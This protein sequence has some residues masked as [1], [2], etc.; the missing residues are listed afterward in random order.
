MNFSSRCLSICH[1]WLCCSV[2]VVAVVADPILLHPFPTIDPPPTKMK[3]FVKFLTV[4]LLLLLLQFLFLLFLFQRLQF[5][6]ELFFPRE[7]F[8]RTNEFPRSLAPRD[9]EQTRNE[10][11]V[12]ICSTTFTNIRSSQANVNFYI[13]V[14]K[15]PLIY[16]FET[17]LRLLMFSI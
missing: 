14:T 8:Q 13:I 2:V 12:R 10:Y 9:C 1:T 7:R 5:N 16:N 15:D 6:S 3:V 4:L 11:F 17:N